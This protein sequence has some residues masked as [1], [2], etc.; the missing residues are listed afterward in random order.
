[1]YSRKAL[2]TIF[3]GNFEIKLFVVYK[4]HVSLRKKRDKIQ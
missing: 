3:F 4:I 1:M 2:F